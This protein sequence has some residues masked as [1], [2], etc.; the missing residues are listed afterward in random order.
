[1]NVKPTR[2]WVL[3][4]GR[5]PICRRGARRMAC[6]VQRRGFAL[7]PLQRHWVR[8]A[9]AAREE[10]IP[11]EMLLLLPDGSLYCGVE[12]FLYLGRRIWWAWPAAML[13]RLPGFKA[14]AKWAYAWL[15]RNRYTLSHACTDE[16]CSL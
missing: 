13:A 2:G 6:A 1:M 15:A 12:A 14:L 8:D 4:D 7:V 16:G 11:D 5:C 3:Y 9:L 10:E